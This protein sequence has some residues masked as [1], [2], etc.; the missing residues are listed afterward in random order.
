V[1]AA[2]VRETWRDDASLHAVQFIDRKIAWTVGD[3]GV[4]LRTTDGGRSWEPRFL[5]A[6]LSFHAVH[7]NSQETGWAAGATTTPYTQVV[8]GAVYQTTDAG[9]TWRQVN[10]VPLPRILAIRFFNERDGIAAGESN[11][12]FASG[13]LVTHDG[14]QNW[15]SVQTAFSSAASTTALTD[16]ANQQLDVVQPS[17]RS[18]GWKAAAFSRLDRG[19]VVGRQSRRAIIARGQLLPGRGGGSDLRSHTGV[20]ITH[21]R[22]GWAVG[23]GG[24]V[25]RTLDGGLVWQAP[26]ALLPELARTLFDFRAID[27][28]GDSIWIAGSPGSL[29]WRSTD[30]GASWH[31]LPTGSALPIHSIDFSTETDGV[32][33]GAMGM[34]LRTADG[35]QTWQPIRAADRRAAMITVA[36][37]PDELSFSSLAKLAGDEGYRA[38]ALLPIRTQ[39]TIQKQSSDFAVHD[40]VIAAGGNAVVADWPLPLSVP[41]L[42][43]DQSALV[44]EWNRVSEGRLEEILI[45][46]IVASIRTWRPEIVTLV[47]PEPSDAAGRIVLEATKIAIAQAADPTRYV[48]HRSALAPWKVKKVY[49]RQRSAQ[50]GDAMIEHDGVLS[51]IGLSVADIAGPAG[52]KIGLLDAAAIS[53][54]TYRLLSTPAEHVA[55]PFF[56][57]L[58]IAPGSAA[59][60][61]VGEPIEESKTAL[62]AS[63]QQTIR[64]YA[65]VAFDDERQ[66]AGLLAQI[67]DVTAG[68]SSAQASR[69]L[70]QVAEAH[71]SRS[72]WDL[73]ER[74]Y[75]AMI[76]RYPLE[77]S[78]R[79][80]MTWLLRLWTGAEPVW[81]RMQ[82]RG[83][84][85]ETIA[86][87]METLEARIDRAFQL[88]EA[89][90]PAASPKQIQLAGLDADPLARTVAPARLQVAAGVSWN[91]ARVAHWREQAMRL[92]GLIR[93]TDPALFATAGVQLPL[94]VAVRSSGASKADTTK[95]LGRDYL[96]LASNAELILARPAEERVSSATCAKAVLP[97]NLDGVFSEPCWKAA[98][99]VRLRTD[100]AH[101]LP[102]G[103]LALLSCDERFLY[104]A[105][106][107]P[108]LADRAAPPIELAGR[109]H[110]ADLST[111]DH[112]VLTLDLDR[113]FATY[114]QFAIDESGHTAE[115]CWGDASWNPQ[116]FASVTGDEDRW[117]IE[118]AIPLADLSPTPLKAGAL[119]AVSISRVVPAVGTQGWPRPS[120]GTPAPDS[121]GLLRFE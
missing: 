9:R 54:E 42:E 14:G 39:T 94:A 24:T 32:A 13:V 1:V 16:A 17:T 114:F 8:V 74:A 86:G 72:Q 10:R 3:H 113:D 36:P 76:E 56:G 96:E 44:A 63:R 11:E 83:A 69:L 27:A 104:V 6:D 116:W 71:R 61:A 12:R 35:G 93:Q 92:G 75:L 62:L 53:R 97:P 101:P 82:H 110:D 100:A 65:A 58:A 84:Q 57:G 28:I 51:R 64:R 106:S 68:L 43:A 90:I 40:A 80:A 20:A 85:Q 111:S 47:E 29:V 107:L 120:D 105:A 109:T 55:K 108:R 118:A 102:D 31:A 99:E 52:A 91:D 59:R 25:L 98:K 88:A 37:R 45:G 121:F 5:P 18:D 49:V 4:A 38:V 22:S 48:E 2:D 70:F 26:E 115:N 66:A 7:F 112:V 79:E 23:D 33:V 117:R 41:G 87:S 77:P 60:R 119:W 67:D 78:S 73:A 95:L 30:G 103:A 50:P 34:I 46:R 81:R 19:A 21:E 15:E 89:G